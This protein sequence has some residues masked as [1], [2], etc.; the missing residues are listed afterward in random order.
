MLIGVE[1]IL[2]TKKTYSGPL[3]HESSVL[4]LEASDYESDVREKSGNPDFVSGSLWRGKGI[5]VG[6]WLVKHTDKNE[7]YLCGMLTGTLHVERSVEVDDEFLYKKDRLTQETKK[8]VEWRI[9]SFDT[10]KWAI[11]KGLT[12][13]AMD[14]LFQELKTQ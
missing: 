1:R 13:T 8:Q 11:Y 12:W 10:L 9:V 7:F 6:T 2:D 14:A 4:R 5:R 3:I